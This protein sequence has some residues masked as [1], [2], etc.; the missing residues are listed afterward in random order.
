MRNLTQLIAEHFKIPI[1]TISD[2]MTSKDV[3]D[4]DSFNYLLFIAELEKE[5]CIT[6]TMDEVLRIQKVGDI[7]KIIEAKNIII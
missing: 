6:L 7:R 3:P 4:W 5:Y 1:E 2:A